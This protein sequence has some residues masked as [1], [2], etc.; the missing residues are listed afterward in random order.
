MDSPFNNLLYSH[1][2]GFQKRKSTEHI[3][4]LD[5]QKAFDVCSH[6][7]RLKNS[8]S[9]TT[10]ENSMIGFKVIWINISGAF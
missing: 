1:Q 3:L 7:I 6:C 10:P 2:Y 9:T 8:K 5:L 4:F